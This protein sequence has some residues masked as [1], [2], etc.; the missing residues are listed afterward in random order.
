MKFVIIIV[1]LQHKNIASFIVLF[2]IKTA[3]NVVISNL[4][5]ICSSIDVL[6]AVELNE[7]SY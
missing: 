1:L 6:L 7:I 3:S 5:I 4:L 2:I